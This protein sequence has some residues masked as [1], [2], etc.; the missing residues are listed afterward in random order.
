MHVS[1]FDRRQFSR[2]N[3]ISNTLQ[4]ELDMA[5]DIQRSQLKNNKC[6][7]QQY[8]IAGHSIACSEVGGDYFDVLSSPDCE[9]GRLK[10][11][12][13]D[14]SGHGV[15]AALLMSS[16]RAFFRI[17]G[18]SADDPSEFVSEMNKYFFQETCGTGNFMTVF[19]L[20]IDLHTGVITWVRAGHDPAVVLTPDFSGFSELKGVGLPLGIDYRYAYKEYR[21]P[22]LIAG[23][24]IAIGTD[25]IWNA[26]NGD[27]DLFGKERFNTILRETS[28]QSAEH[29]IAAVFDD[30]SSFCKDVPLDDDITLVV[31]KIHPDMGPVARDGRWDNCVRAAM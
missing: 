10:I 7:V 19:H 1:T 15:A 30:L 16:A 11:I 17:R 8:E 25:G 22:P 28:H 24:V 13:G 26:H 5:G 20:S 29:T 3:L 9:T 23:S 31:I 27:G 18:S 6:Y 14:V 12:V 2:Q 4:H 21:L